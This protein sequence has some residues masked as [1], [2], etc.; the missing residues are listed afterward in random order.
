MW[1]TNATSNVQCLTTNWNKCVLC[2][3]DTSDVLRCP[4]FSKYDA[5]GVGYKTSTDDINGFH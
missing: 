1:Q 3:V 5:D 2:Q 4:A